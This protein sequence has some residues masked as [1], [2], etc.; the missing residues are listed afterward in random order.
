M[1][2]EQGSLAVRIAPSRQDI[3]PNW[4]LKLGLMTRLDKS[5]TIGESV[6]MKEGGRNREVRSPLLH[7]WLANQEILYGFPAMAREVCQITMDARYYSDIS[8][9][10]KWPGMEATT[11]GFDDSVSAMLNEE[12]DIGSS[13][14]IMGP[15]PSV[16]E[17]NERMNKFK[18]GVNETTK[19]TTISMSKNSSQQYER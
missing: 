17:N 4:L 5:I 12:Q 18:I 14:V 19:E 9:P 2:A 3:A 8:S 16:P 1:K 15:L 11:K 6:I 10:M 7:L 13:L